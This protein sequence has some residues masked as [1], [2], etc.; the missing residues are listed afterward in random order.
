MES[1]NELKEIDIKNCTCYYFD[2]TIKIENFNLDSILISEKPYQNIFVHLISYKTLINAKPLRIR[3]DKIDDLLE[4]VMEL[5]T[6]YYLEERNMILFTRNQVSCRSKTWYHICH[7][8]KLWKIKVDS[9]DSL[10]LEKKTM[11]FYVIILIKSGFYKIFLEKACH[12]LP[13]E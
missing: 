7:F 1:N 2:E 5:A 6:Q 12:E 9:Y 11:I 4:F 8:S 13:K 10:H 3:F